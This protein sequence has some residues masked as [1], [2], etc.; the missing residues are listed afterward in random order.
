MSAA[1]LAVAL[2]H[3]FMNIHAIY[4]PPTM[5]NYINKLSCLYTEQSNV[6]V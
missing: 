5:N 2:T 6:V 1:T 3:F 4:A